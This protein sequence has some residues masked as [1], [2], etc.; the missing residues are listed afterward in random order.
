M[1]AELAALPDGTYAFE[2]FIDGVGE[3][4]EPLRIAVELTVRGDEV[5]VDFEGTAPQVAGGAQLP[6]RHG[7]RRRLLR[8]PRHRRPRDPE[9]RRLHAA[10]PHQRAGGHDREPGATGG[11]RRARRRRLPRLR[12]GHGRARAGRAG[13][14]DRAGRGR[15]DADRDRRLRGREAVRPDRGDRRLLG[16]ARERATGSRACRTRSPTSRTSPSSWS[17]ATCRCG[18]TA[19]GSSP[20]RAAPGRFRGGLAYERS[21]ELLADEAVLT[22]RSDRRSHPPYGIEGGEA[23]APSSNTIARPAASASVA[24]DA[25]GGAE[26]APGRRLPP[27]LRRRRRQRLAVRARPGARARG[28]PRREGERRGGAR[29]LRRRH[30]RR[31]GG[32][33]AT[34]AARS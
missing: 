22:V 34:A 13:P 17:R 12:R 2:D 3:E 18:C 33:G 25:D 30:R 9:R 15:A 23:G 8:V 4:P 24:D 14:G 27:R 1:R 31:P 16:R 7:Q 29:A 19:T 28:R 6:G 5:W 26:A 20:T 21:F 11:L 32:R 10:D